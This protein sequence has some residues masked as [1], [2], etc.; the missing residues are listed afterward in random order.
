MSDKPTPLVY[1]LQLTINNPQSV[2]QDSDATII[3]IDL[4]NNVNISQSVIFGE[5]IGIVVNAN[6]TLLSTGKFLLTKNATYTISMMMKIPDIGASKTYI[7]IQVVN[8]DTPS[9]FTNTETWINEIAFIPLPNTDQQLARYVFTVEDNDVYVGYQVRW[10]KNV[11]HYNY[12]LTQGNF[13]VTLRLE[14]LL[15][16]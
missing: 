8:K 16:S 10:I 15:F 1:F 6:N 9:T 4:N 2:L 7:N 14:K 11:A 13:P 5:L 3:Q 12:I